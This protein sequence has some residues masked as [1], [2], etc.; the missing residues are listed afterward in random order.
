MNLLT[1]EH[2]TKGTDATNYQVNNLPEFRQ[3]ISELNFEIKNHL[4]IKNKNGEKK[5]PV[6]A[7][8]ENLYEVGGKKSF[9]IVFTR[10]SKN[11]DV[12]PTIDVVF[13]DPFFDTGISHFMFEQDKIDNLPELQFIKK[14]L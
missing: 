2:E 5:F 12:S 1:I 13:Q 4:F 3:R 8:F 9:Y 14:N 6:L 11:K 7:T 10:D